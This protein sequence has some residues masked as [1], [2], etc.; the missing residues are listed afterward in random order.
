MI[1]CTPE[2]LA[3]YIIA[4]D[5]VD[6]VETT[7]PQGEIR[8]A[9][10]EINHLN[11]ALDKANKEVNR[12]NAALDEKAKP[13]YNENGSTAIYINEMSRPYY[14]LKWWQLW[15]YNPYWDSKTYRYRWVR[16][17]FQYARNR[18]SSDD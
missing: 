15:R 10:M 3:F 7:L 14:P 5:D 6:S 12:L 13:S 4:P 9:I 11:A 17:L 16:S 8:K 1:Y 18:G 2:K